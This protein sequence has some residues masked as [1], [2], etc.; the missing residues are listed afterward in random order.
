MISILYYLTYRS[1]L[2]FRFTLAFSF[3]FALLF[4]FLLF[5]FR[6]FYF[7]GWGRCFFSLFDYFWF[8]LFTWFS[9]NWVGRLSILDNVGGFKS[10]FFAILAL[11]DDLL[12]VVQFRILNWNSDIDLSILVYYLYIFR[13][14][15]FIVCSLIIFS[16]FL[17][18]GFFSLFYFLLLLFLLNFF[19]FLNFTLF[20]SFRLLYFLFRLLWIYSTLFN[21]FRSFSFRL[22]YNFLYCFWNWCLLRRCFFCLLLL[23]LWNLRFFSHLFLLY[24][25]S[26]WGRLRRFSL[27]LLLW[28]LYFL[29]LCLFLLNNRFFLLFCLLHF[30]LGFS[31]SILC[32]DLLGLDGL[33]FFLDF[34]LNFLLVHLSR[35]TLFFFSL[36]LLWWGLSI[37]AC[38][39]FPLLHLSHTFLTS[40]LILLNTYLCHINLN[41]LSCRFNFE[42]SR[43]SI[44]SN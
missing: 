19:N 27:Y 16:Y 23:N 43:G 22:F 20:L 25:L 4:G 29:L 13:L 2:S 37:F 38:F 5:C 17:L 42:Q 11:N 8:I 31:I 12:S 33:N 6:W 32:L 30:F 40:I 14:D 36:N 44:G 18:A 3:F 9:L 1:G 7:S 21:F 26:F 35:L 34:L 39:L 28:L 24:L 10:G 41:I 15:L